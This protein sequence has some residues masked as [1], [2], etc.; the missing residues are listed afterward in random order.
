MKRAEIGFT[1]IELLVVISI[2]AILATIAGPSM[3]RTMVNSRMQEAS[4][5]VKTVLE[6]A[7]AESFASQQRVSVTFSGDRFTFNNPNGGTKIVYL[8]SNIVVTPQAAVS[9]GIVFNKGIPQTTTN[10]PL[11]GTGTGYE[12]CYTGETVNKRVV[13]IQGYNI[14]TATK[15]QGGCA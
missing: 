4:E 13:A 12:I 8:N 6:Q 7:R 14:I 1:L 11:G 3:K 10:E 2:V 5:A 15:Q 9:G